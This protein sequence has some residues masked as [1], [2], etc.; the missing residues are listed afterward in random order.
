MRRQGMQMKI[1]WSMLGMLLS[2]WLLPLLL[3]TFAIFSFMSIRLNRQMQNT[4]ITSADS[5]IE[6][7]QRQLD[8]VINAS[9]QA[10]YITTIYDSYVDYQKTGNE[11]ELY[12]K[13]SN[14]LAQQYKYNKNLLC[15]MLY[16]VDDPDNIYATYSNR[17][18]TDANYT[19]V[20]K[21]RET[22]LGK[23]KE[24]TAQLST[25]T[26][27]VN[28]D[29]RIY[30]IRNMVDRNYNPYAV[31][32]MELNKSHIFESLESIWGAE[33]YN[34][35]LGQTPLIL[36]GTPK[37]YYL[38]KMQKV[39]EKSIFEDR[40]DSAY[41]YKVVRQGRYKMGFMIQLDTEALDSEM[42]MVNYVFTLVMIFMFPLVFMVYGFFHRKV[43]KPVNDLIS[44]SKEIAMGNYGLQIEKRANSREFAYLNGTFNSMSLELKYQFE[45]I[46]VEELA[47][48]DA[49][50]MALQSQINPHFLNNTLENINWEARL[51][52]NDK[53]SGMIEAL[54][55]MLSA[56]MNRENKNTI[57]LAE[58]LAYVDAYL[59]II[60]QRFG[61]RLAVRK[62]IDEKLLQVD[63]PRLIIQP[64]IENA[65]EHGMQNRSGKE[66][67]SMTIYAVEDK[68]YIEIV[69]SGELSAHDKD[70]IKYLLETENINTKERSLSL[71]IRNVNKR[72]K[73]MYGDECGLTIKS[74]KENSTISTIIVKLN[75]ENNKNQ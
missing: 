63:I 74:Y 12:M 35:F 49:N 27:I 4:I 29:G 42:K 34:I 40:K 48:K 57:T 3:I 44:A 51:Q 68:V 54:S 72:I 45:K 23:I 59:Y 14:F 17:T 67:V 37:T 5:A 31:I 26:E 11:E 69:N 65:I 24:R 38:P 39:T 60:T 58:E 21:F 47:L 28:T 46:Y 75:N 66:E 1:Q 2:C 71:G 8:S 10:S 6:M 15:T 32:V 25:G 30:L 64:I 9:R 73:I 33:S 20:K 55:T 61:N 13:V 50:I 7:C 18:G 70:K 36:S 22:A 19:S 43:T 52:G 41:V 62:N 56:T 16:F 53:V